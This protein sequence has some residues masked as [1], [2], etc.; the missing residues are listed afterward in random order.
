[1]RTE[2]ER[3]GEEGE[4]KAKVTVKG[5]R[6]C[7]TSQSLLS[8]ARHSHSLGEDVGTWTMALWRLIVAKEALELF[9]MN[10]ASSV[11]FPLD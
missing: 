5:G 7:V 8:R 11:H 3:G 6:D 4:E 1:M 10:P 2:H 9:A